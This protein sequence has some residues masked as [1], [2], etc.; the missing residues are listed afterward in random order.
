LLNQS[1]LKKQT[2][3]R[4]KLKGGDTLM[5]INKTL[6]ITAAGSVLYQEDVDKVLQDLIEHNNPLRQNL[7][8]KQGSGQAWILTQRTAD[9]T[10]AF[11]NDV[12]EPAYANSAYQ[13]L[14]FAY[15]T[16]LARGKVTR[17]LQAQGKSLLDIESEE[18]MASLDVVRDTEEN[19][20]FYGDSSVNAKAFD[21]LKKQ[22]V[23]GQTVS[24]GANGG[25]LT[26][27]T[28]DQAND[29]AIGSPDMI[30]ASKRTKRE[31]N[32]LLQAQQRF[33]DQVEVKGGFRV[34]S[35]NGTPIFY[36][37]QISEAETQGTNN[38][39]SSLYFIDTSKTWMGVLTE[40][41]MQ[42]F[43]QTS[44]QYQQFDLFEDLA[45][46]QGNYLYNSKI[47]GIL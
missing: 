11:V 24:L 1:V 3:D 19:A 8:R 39:A 37:H 10:S 20:I 6:D 4:Q 7:P 16:I 42:K 9:P 18:M 33:V 44:S 27:A 26:L 5:D 30:A 40:L 34:A 36:S 25:N 2:K 32:A 47:V 45:L 13:R 14:S 12:E 35:Y 21:G 38:F 41:T 31:I 15:K 46:V 28:L 17:K 43:G 23:A 29:L 22:I